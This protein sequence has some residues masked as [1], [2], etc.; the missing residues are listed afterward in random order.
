MGWSGFRGVV[1]TL[2]MSLS[3]FS[4]GVLDLGV[5]FL[6]ALPLEFTHPRPVPPSA[7]QCVPGPSV[8]LSE[9]PF[10]HSSQGHVPHQA[11]M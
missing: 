3:C 6:R 4:L 1:G 8:L 11:G 9:P 2:G 10:L 7:F 5:S